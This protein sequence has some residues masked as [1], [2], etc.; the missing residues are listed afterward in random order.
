MTKTVEDFQKRYSR[1]RKTNQVAVE[2][3]DS[4]EEDDDNEKGEEEDPFERAL[5]LYGRYINIPNWTSGRGKS[6]KQSGKGTGRRIYL[7]STQPDQL[8]KKDDTDGE[9]KRGNEEIRKPVVFMFHGIGGSLNVWRYQILYLLRAGYGVVAM[10]LYGHG[11]S[12]GRA[13]AGEGKKGDENDGGSGSEGSKGG[14]PFH[15][16]LLWR[17]ALHIFDRFGE[18]TQG[19]QEQE[20][21]AGSSKGGVNVVMGHS[22][23]V[24][25]AVRLCVE[26]PVQVHGI[27]LA[28][29]GAPVGLGSEKGCNWY[30]LPLCVLWMLKPLIQ[31]RFKRMASGADSSSRGKATK[32]NASDSEPD[33]KP[34]E[35]EEKAVYGQD[36]SAHALQNFSIS[37]RV[38]KGYMLGQDW[39]EGDH[40]YHRRIRQQALVI[41]GDEDSLVTFQEDIHMRN[42]LR[43]SEWE[44]IE[45]AGHMVMLDNPRVFNKYLGEFIQSLPA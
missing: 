30:D 36:Q 29:G 12:T 25:F 4:E 32:D 38:L 34:D 10:D 37:T 5:R 45:D 40:A 35:E 3:D 28:N 19:Q 18:K 42:C 15:F 8:E 1:G 27:I 44:C 7:L 26:R 33:P 13:I 14:N 43:N 23:G 9:D 22:Y 11:K 41:H 24:A 17:D 16:S 20:E 39:P 31:W 6:G 21:E 2:H